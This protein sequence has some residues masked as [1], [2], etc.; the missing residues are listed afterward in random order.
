MI[1]L[2]R[3]ELIL[4]H[5]G[6]EDFK[7]LDPQEIVVAQWV[8]MKCEFGCPD[9]GRLASCPPN[10][11]S[12][13]ECQRFFLEY[14]NAIVLHFQKVAPD[15]AV[16]KTWYTRTNLKLVRLE[17]Q[18]FLEGYPK[19][20]ALFLDSCAICPECV[21]DRANCKKPILSRPTVE[22]MAVDIFSTV[23]KLGFPIDVLTD[24]NQTMNRYAFLMIE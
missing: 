22:G 10:L 18:V 12:V 17:Q 7:W 21:P 15:D 5:H 3:I 6:Y 20:F 23:R 2:K 24:P 9:Y 19:S 11:P 13:E 1:D 14:K 4:H 16:R 8:R